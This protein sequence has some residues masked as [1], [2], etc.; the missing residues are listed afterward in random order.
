MARSTHDPTARGT[1]LWMS[2]LTLAIMAGV[3]AFDL[4]VPL[5][6]ATGI[7]YTAAVLVALWS[8]RRSF[9][10]AVAVVGSALTVLG[11]L[12]KLPWAAAPPFVFLTNRIL[13]V[14]CIWAVAVV[15]LQRSSL[16]RRVQGLDQEKNRFLGIVAHDLRNPLAVLRGSM[17]LLLAE[18]PDA[19]L[20]KRMDRTAAKMTTLVNDLLDVSALEAGRITIKPR[21]VDLARL[22][23][24]VC[25]EQQPIAEERHMTLRSDVPTGL[26]EALVD[27]DRIEQ[28][29]CNLIGNA[30]KFSSPEAVIGVGARLR[31][32]SLLEVC[33]TD[34]GPGIPAGELDHIFD[35]FRRG[36]IDPGFERGVGLGLAIARRM[37]EA[38][39]GTIWVTSQPGDGARF[40]FTLPTVPAAR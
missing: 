19:S 40:M 17:R 26:P 7:G 32:D 10:L 12:V 29:L 30:L 2:V 9:I 18:T 1:S 15:G 37:V 4:S 25:E 36:S 33:V 5:G 22:V 3:L 20:L 23:A 35:E 14:V 27:P 6:I 38:H 28:V 8:P 11:L 16:L 34:Q 13:S 24:E 31:G 39:G 21:P